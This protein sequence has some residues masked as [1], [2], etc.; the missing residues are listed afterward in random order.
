MPA[1]LTVAGR[2][3]AVLIAL[4]TLGGC[5]GRGDAGAAAGA[6]RRLEV[7]R[8]SLE[9]HVLLTGELVAERG[10]ALVAPNARI[11][12]L[13]IRW[14]V[15]DGTQVAAG[16]RLVE[17]DASQLGANLEELRLGM[18]EASQRLTT[19]TAQSAAALADARFA[20]DRARAAVE[21]ARLAATV[22]G[23]LFSSSELARRQ[24]ELARA[25]L[26]LGTA[27]ARLASQEQSG[28]ADVEM[29][30]LAVERARAELERA[31]ATVTQ[32]TLRAPGA[33][34]AV[35]AVNPE[36]GRPFLSGDTVWPGMTVVSLPDLGSLVAEA[37]LFDVDDG[38]V[39]PGMPVEAVIDAFPGATLR[40]RVRTVA[41]F[42]QATGW[43]SLR[44][45]FRVVADL[46]GVDPSRML[47]GMSVQL[48]V[49]PPAL[50][51][52]LLVPRESLAFGDTGALATRADGEP[53]AVTL[54]PCSASECVVASG[55]EEAERLGRPGDRR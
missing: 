27:E 13:Q 54:G 52:V 31:E 8:G 38:Q 11:W 37:R 10:D 21:T 7:R 44:R 36:E 29:Q 22:P 50:D 30:Q 3:A 18:V 17:F 35:V 23:E 53:V 41:S 26:E 4:C 33:G 1:V 16:E 47:P 43:R 19:L 46:E 28:R 34:L 51:D 55:L 48:V 14:V 6:P 42:A 32:L 25:E 24:L 49:T 2:S 12:P 5:A 15:D 40:G 45:Y 39:A 9:R 20:V